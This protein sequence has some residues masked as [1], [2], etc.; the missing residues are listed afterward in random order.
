MRTRDWKEIDPAW[1][2][3]PFHLAYE[4]FANSNQNFWSNGTH[5]VLYS[6]FGHQYRDRAEGGA[7]GTLAPPPHF[8]VK[9]KKIKQKII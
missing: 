6:R 1:W 2:K 5:P 4:N 7:E 3:I 8:F 9:I